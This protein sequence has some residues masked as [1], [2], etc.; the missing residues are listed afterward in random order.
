MPDI[1]PQ[2]SEATS[3]LSET[4]VTA[5]E[6]SI[7]LS[8]AKDPSPSEALT[9]V[10]LDEPSV[11]LSKAK[12]FSLSEAPKDEDTLELDRVLEEELIIEDFTIDGICGV[13]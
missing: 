9:N 12:D 3:I 13:Y 11:I 5:D 10:N 1:N 7:I 6:P 8:E 4:R 2:T